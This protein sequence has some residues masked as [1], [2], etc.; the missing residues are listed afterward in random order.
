VRES[1]P[2]PDAETATSALDEP[3][4]P[5]EQVR[6]RFRLQYEQILAHDPGSRLGREPEAVHRF[7]VAV[8]RLR[9]LLRSLGSGVD[10]VWADQ[11]RAELGWLGRA[12]GEVRDR[13]VLLLRLRAQ[14]E[15]LDATDR[16]GAETLLKRLEGE[17]AEARAGLG[18]VLGSGRYLTLLARLEEAAEAPRWVGREEQ[19][20]EQLAAKE[21]RRLQ[22]AA[23]VLGRDPSDEQLHKARIRAKRARYAAE[24]AEPAVGKPARRVIERARE[25][26]DVSGEHQDAVVAEETLR[27]L[28]E[29]A[30]PQVAFSAG[31]LAELQHER[32][33]RARREIPFAWKRLDKA[34]RRAWR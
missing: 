32:R 26:Q 25:F 10:R 4:S 19:R 9:A 30:E 28:A 23:A 17:R 22:K 20:L 3:G 33:L 12:L 13:D 21:F 8:R 34:G 2:E 7:R 1:D 24:V 18:S 16:A 27:R 5:R 29:G 6:A 11:L 31:R 15:E 14:V